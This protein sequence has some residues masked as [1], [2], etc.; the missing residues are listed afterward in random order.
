MKIIKPPYLADAEWDETPAVIGATGNR[1]IVRLGT[2][3]DSLVVVFRRR[4]RDL[5][6]EGDQGRVEAQVQLLD[7]LFEGLGA[8]GAVRREVGEVVG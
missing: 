1:D 6:Q 5:V 3:Q 7:L 4:V 8:D 2:F